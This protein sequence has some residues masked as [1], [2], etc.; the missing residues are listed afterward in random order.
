V[1]VNVV[2]FRHFEF[3][4]GLPL[5]TRSQTPVPRSPFPVPR[6]PFPVT[7][8]SNIHLW[9][10][11]FV[12][13]M[14]TSMLIVIIILTR[15]VFLRKWRHVDAVIA[16][17]IR[18]FNKTTTAPAT[19]TLLKGLG[20]VHINLFSKEDG[21]AV[22]LRIRL[23]STLQRRKRSPKTKSFE[24]ALQSGTIW[25]RYFL[26]E[27]LFS[28]VDGEND[29]IWKRWR[30]PN[31]HDRAPAQSTVSIQNS[32]QTVPCGFSLDNRC[33]VEGRK[34]YKNDKC[35][36]KSFWKRSKTAPFSFQNGLVWTGPNEQYNACVRAL[37][38]V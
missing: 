35:G 21:A 18:K 32:E 3:S 19:G 6:S 36:H 26:T 31:R 10:K 7:S 8:F 15:A 4:G 38:S 5:F 1:F 23:S 34:R 28:S 25:K 13:L 37:S 12:I 30:H 2:F 22:L 16:Y 33:S 9:A 20:P 27:T 29:A 24:N 17:T 11:A 14:R